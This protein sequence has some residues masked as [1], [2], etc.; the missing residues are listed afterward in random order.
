MFQVRVIHVLLTEPP[1]VPS[2]ALVVGRAVND[3]PGTHNLLEGMDSC[4]GNKQGLGGSGVQ[5]GE[6]RLG[7]Q[8]WERDERGG[9]L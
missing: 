6:E 4:C 8:W 3:T 9:G 5:V 1:H 2:T 7:G